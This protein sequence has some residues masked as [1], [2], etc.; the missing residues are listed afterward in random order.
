MARPPPNHEILGASVIVP[1]Y[2]DLE[3]LRACVRALRD[4]ADPKARYEIIVADN[5]SPAGVAEVAERCEG[6]ARVVLAR[7]RGAAMA[8]N[9]GVAASSG[10]I[11]VFTDSDCRPAAD[12]VAEGLAALDGFDF[13]GGR[14]EVAVQDPDHLTAEEAFELVFAFQNDINVTRKGFSASANLIVPR[15]VFDAVG[16]FRNGAPEDM[17]WCARARAMGFRIGYAPAAVVRHPARRTWAE[18]TRKWR[19]LTGEFCFMYRRRRFGVLLWVA[20]GL[21]L[22]PS[23]APHALVALRSPRLRRWRDRWGAIRVLARLRALRFV[24]TYKVLFGPL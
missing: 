17:D 11:L 2:D 9:A 7:E 19:R 23:I 3:N 21:L 6:G 5:G 15:R 1:H 8:R 18:L 16:P 24:W 13:I 12:F 20:R 14:I 22:I 4:Q 10:G